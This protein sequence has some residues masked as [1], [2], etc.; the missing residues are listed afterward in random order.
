M[1]MKSYRKT[2]ILVGILFITATAASI[3]GSLIILDPILSA[4][5]YLVTV[6]ENEMQVIAG[7]LIDGINSLAVVGIAVLMFP[8]LKKQHENAAQGYVGF[9]IL[10]SAILLIGSIS[11]L[12][13]VSLSQETVQETA[14]EASYLQTLGDLLLAASDWAQMLGAMIVFS[15]TALILNYSLYQS[16]LVPRSLSIWGIVGAILMFAAGLLSVFGLGYLSPISVLLGLP[17]ALQE[18][19]FAVWLIVKG[20][21]LLLDV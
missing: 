14:A 11:L 5:N 6:S 19:V 18:M 20:F 7:V 10:E 3:V 17:M 21:N 9:R 4:P 12:S 15:L 13:L 8:V 2:A 1:E 16:K